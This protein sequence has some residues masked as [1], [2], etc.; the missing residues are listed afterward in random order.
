MNDGWDL[1]SSDP[2]KSGREILSLKAHP[3]EAIT[4]TRNALI[5][6]HTH[7][8]SLRWASL[9]SFSIF[10]NL[11]LLFFFTLLLS[12]LSGGSSIRLFSIYLQ[13]PPTTTPPKR[14]EE[15]PQCVEWSILCIYRRSC[16]NVIARFKYSIFFLYTRRLRWWRWWL[17]FFLSSRAKRE[18]E[19]EGVVLFF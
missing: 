2:I 14:D 19:E 6:T 3:P 12:C 10:I 9:F 18:S 8:H 11:L 7:T 5:C 4:A 1:S 16:V 13:T 15:I 17:F